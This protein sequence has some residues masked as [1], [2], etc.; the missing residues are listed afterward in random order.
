M[1]HCPSTYRRFES[2]K[3]LISTYSKKLN[4][5]PKSKIKDKRIINH[6]EANLEAY[7]NTSQIDNNERNPKVQNK[8]LTRL[9]RP[10][11]INR[12]KKDC[13][14]QSLQDAINNFFASLK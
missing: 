5:L 12:G 10:I 3:S 2:L 4:S 6:E 7:S 1:D 9:N 13:I 11:M 8:R 14:P